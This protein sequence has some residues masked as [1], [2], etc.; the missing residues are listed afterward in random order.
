MEFVKKNAQKKN[1]YTI[2]YNYNYLKQFLSQNNLIVS[3][4]DTEINF[5]VDSLQSLEDYIKNNFLN[6]AFINNFI[7]DIGSQIFNLKSQNFYILY[8]SLKDII[9]INSNRFLFIN[10]NKVLSIHGLDKLPYINDEEFIPPELFDRSNNKN[11]WVRSEVGS[12]YSLAKL[13]LFVFNLNLD[14]LYYTKIYFFLTR[15][16]QV[17][18][19]ERIFLYI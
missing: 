3:I 2:D 10:P 8:F 9:I 11:N 7:Y 1:N 12:Y 17:V 14:N 5:Q 6:D 18:P 16:L 13:I 15:C 4:N 19:A